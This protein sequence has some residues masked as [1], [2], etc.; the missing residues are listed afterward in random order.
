MHYHYYYY[1]LYI[2][3]TVILLDH[4]KSVL[5]HVPQYQKIS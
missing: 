4:K 3:L 1:A 5:Q 2:C